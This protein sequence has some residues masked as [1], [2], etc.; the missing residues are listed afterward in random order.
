[1]HYINHNFTDWDFDTKHMNRIEKTI[2]LDLRSDYFCQEK[3][4]D[5]ANRDLL[6]RRLN[7]HSDDEKQALAFVLKDKFKKKG[8]S[9]V[10]P[11]WDKII[12]DYRYQE[13]ITAIGDMTRK[14]KKAGFDVPVNAGT[15]AIREAYAK[16]F[17]FDKLTR[18]TNKANAN[19]IAN[20]ESKNGNGANEKENANAN[21][22]AN[23]E[24]DNANA[25]MTNAERQAK[26]KA[27]RKFLVEKLRELGEQ[28]T[29]KTA[30]DSLRSLYNS[31]F[32][33]D[34]IND[35][36]AVETA[37]ERENSNANENANEQTLTANGANEKENDNANES[38]GRKTA[39]T[40]NHKPLTI[41]H[42]PVT[43]NQESESAPAKSET[44]NE[45]LAS[46]H[47]SEQPQPL[48][49][50]KNEINKNVPPAPKFIDPE[51]SDKAR[52]VR[53]QRALQVEDWQEPSFVD[54]KELLFIAGKQMNL[55]GT[56]YRMMVE[57][58]KAYYAGQADMGKALAPRMIPNKFRQWLISEVE[59]KA[60]LSQT[61]YQGQNHANHQSANSQYQQPK[62][63]SADAYAA[64]LARQLAEYDANQYQ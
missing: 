31:H 54:A 58:F 20:G 42:E 48:V 6:E 24:T 43:K 29:Q 16:H 55:T 62:Q 39:I 5:A 34:A 26:S 50:E 7:I 40:I 12:K 8:S 15:A 11:E 63:S 35:M 21:E 30:I 45:I 33:S 18:I 56:E 64:D 60:T 41:N 14:L 61:N 38:N 22:S 19:A 59:K 46:K 13:L 25:P 51:I 27:E 3:P 47:N 36:E 32:G 9:Y 2:Y 23:S 4:I 17:G 52:D 44:A 57:D 49:N 53:E 1:M 28:V 37:N 10:A